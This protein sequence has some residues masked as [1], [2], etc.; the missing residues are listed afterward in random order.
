[1]TGIPS[2]HRI[3]KVGKTQ[4]IVVQMGAVQLL[5]LHPGPAVL[6]L[7]HGGLWGIHG[8]TGT[9]MTQSFSE[10]D[11][12]EGA[13]EVGRFDCSICSSDLGGDPHTSH[14]PKPFLLICLPLMRNLKARFFLSLPFLQLTVTETSCMLGGKM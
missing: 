13:S 11:S 5:R 4:A 14:S 7:P 1:M 12:T 8:H 6:T 3:A 9:R 10:A 2:F